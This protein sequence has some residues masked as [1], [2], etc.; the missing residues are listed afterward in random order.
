MATVN[1]LEVMCRIGKENG[2]T[3]WVLRA[4]ERVVRV[5]GPPKR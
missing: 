3:L 4:E 5:K 2:P 1:V